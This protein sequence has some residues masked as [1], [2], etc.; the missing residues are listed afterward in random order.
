LG[1]TQEQAAARGNMPEPTYQAI[2]GAKRK[3]YRATTLNRLDRSLDWLPGTAARMMSPERYRPDQPDQPVVEAIGSL[4]TTMAQLVQAV[5]DLRQEPSL[6]EQLAQIWEQLA[7]EDQ[8][9]LVQLALRLRNTRHE[10]PNSQGGA[11]S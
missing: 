1:L 3:S 8:Q 5:R 9:Q 7:P 10:P 2:E 11:G 6:P 4:T